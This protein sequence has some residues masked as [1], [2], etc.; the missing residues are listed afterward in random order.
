MSKIVYCLR[1]IAVQIGGFAITIWTNKVCPN[2]RR[3]ISIVFELNTKLARS[4]S[5]RCACTVEALPKPT[6]SRCP[7]KRDHRRHSRAFPP[8]QTALKKILNA[9]CRALNMCQKKKKPYHFPFGRPISQPRTAG[10]RLVF[11]EGRGTQWAFDT[12]EPFNIIY[13]FNFFFS[14]NN[15]GIINPFG[16][17]TRRYNCVC[18]IVLYTARAA[19]AVSKTSGSNGKIWKI[20][21]STHGR[22]FKTNLAKYTDKPVWNDKYHNDGIKI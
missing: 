19:R 4:T 17:S 14:L 20:T 2:V 10:T 22:P 18:I 8:R 21:A 3:S 11:D 15:A 7:H 13:F 6:L 9:C 5:Y 1:L 12:G 16:T